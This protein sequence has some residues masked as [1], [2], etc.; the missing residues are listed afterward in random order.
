MNPCLKNSTVYIG[1]NYSLYK[2]PVAVLSP[3]LTTHLPFLFK[4]ILST[5]PQTET[6]ASDGEITFD[7]LGTTT[8]L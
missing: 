4:A 3:F 7:R 5:L 6:P 2:K 1:C 8:E